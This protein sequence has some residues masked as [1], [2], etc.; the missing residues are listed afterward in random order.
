MKPESEKAKNRRVACRR[1]LKYGMWDKIRWIRRNFPENCNTLYDNASN[2][3]ALSDP[4]S[5]KPVH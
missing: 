3:G 1:R 5:T 2:L 4:Y